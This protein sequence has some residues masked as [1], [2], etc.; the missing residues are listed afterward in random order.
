[1]AGPLLQ[2]EVV[3][4]VLGSMDHCTHCQVFLDGA[5]VGGTVHQQDLDAYPKEWMEH[6][7]RLSDLIFSLTE[8]HPGQL[9]VKIT[10]A[11]SPQGLWAAIRKGVR[12]YPTFI[13]GGDKYTGFDEGAV[14]GLIARVFPHA[15]HA[16]AA[17]SRAAA[18]ALGES[19]FLAGALTG[20]SLP[21][22]LISDYHDRQ[23]NPRFRG[24]RLG[25]C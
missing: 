7:K 19:V 2:V 21:H 5:G 6:W 25:G 4:H 22:P 12:K 15:V 23:R 24:W 13:L 11:Q 16:P 8:N 14:R 9:V 17:V 20:G 10:D 1:M 3:A 18:H